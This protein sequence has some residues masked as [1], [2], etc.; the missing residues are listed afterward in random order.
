MESV[1]RKPL[2]VA[3]AVAPAIML[4]SAGVCSSLVAQ[5]ST[6]ANYS[7]GFFVVPLALYFAWERREAFASAAIRPGL[8]GLLLIAGSLLLW[9]A[10]TLGSELFLTRVSM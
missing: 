1:D 5:W 9:A 8:G 7:H 6:D 10:G 3:A 4:T 2:G